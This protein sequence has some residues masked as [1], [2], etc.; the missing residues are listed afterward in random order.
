MPT[1]D[2]IYRYG[3]DTTV[4]QLI[5]VYLTEHRLT[6]GDLAR[7]LDVT[8]ELVAEWR[9]GKLTTGLISTK[10]NTFQ[11]I[12]G[13]DLGRLM[14]LEA[15]RQL[16]KEGIAC[17]ENMYTTRAEVVDELRKHCA[18]TN[19]VLVGDQIGITGGVIQ[20][21]LSGRQM[22]SLEYMPIVLKGI[23][24]GFLPGTVDDV[25]Y[26]LIKRQ[27]F[28][29]DDPLTDLPTFR[30][31]LEEVLRH[32]GALGHSAFA[33]WSGMNISVVR[34]LHTYKSTKESTQET[35]KSLI[36][37]V[38][39]QRR[40]DLLKLFDK[41]WPEQRSRSR[42]TNHQPANTPVETGAKDISVAVTPPAP[43]EPVPTPPAM[44]APPDATVAPVALPTYSRLV[45]VIETLAGQLIALGTTA[46][47]LQTLAADLRANPPS[48]PPAAHWNGVVSGK[49]PLGTTI[50]GLRF[51]LT[52]E[53]FRPMPGAQLSEAE[54]EDTVALCEELRR[55][56]T[57]L[58]QFDP[59]TRNRVLRRLGK[60]IDEL[61]IV[62]GLHK[63]E[64]PSGSLHV[65]NLE[66]GGFAEIRKDQ[67]GE[68]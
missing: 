62:M 66:R 43:R 49:E 6:A 8:D 1:P 36:R 28:K 48:P 64:T 14:I 47:N 3:P 30:H 44:P 21:W 55:R 56:M 9:A 51:C 34:R 50:D 25:R 2:G 11:K 31:L 46:G 40:R 65:L 26:A 13:I 33:R 58:V 41:P 52:A 68:S 17:P 24:N 19:C 60:E 59:T 7:K 22:P 42:T 63:T 32:Q 57:L 54:M 10:A 37:M 39:S 5:E 45:G 16:W 23:V 12:T 4:G 27:L 67:E 35:I 38:V 18:A 29:E 20:G 15:K 53:T 61:Y